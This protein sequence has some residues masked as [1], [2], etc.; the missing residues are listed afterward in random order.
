MRLRA[1]FM[2]DDEER[3]KNLKNINDMEALIAE[4]M[5]FAKLQSGTATN[6]T[7]NFSALVKSIV[8]DA[9]DAGQDVSV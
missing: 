8:N 6:D 3:E 5:D 1:E 2:E 4:I 7:V 9:Q